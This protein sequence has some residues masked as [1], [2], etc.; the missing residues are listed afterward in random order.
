MGNALAK[1]WTDRAEISEE[2]PRSAPVVVAVNI[3]CKLYWGSGAPVEKG[4][5]PAVSEAVSVNAK[6]FLAADIEVKAG[7][8]ISVTRGTRTFVFSRSGEPLVFTKHQEIP[9]ALER[10]YA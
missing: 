7:S 4:D 1:M 3:P 6:L 9:L 8:K 10:R 5:F 2:R